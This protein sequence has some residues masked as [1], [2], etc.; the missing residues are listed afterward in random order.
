[1]RRRP[2]TLLV[3]TAVLLTA[4]ARYTEQTSPCFGRD[5][6]PQVSRA[7]LSLTTSD[8]QPSAAAKDCVFEELPRAV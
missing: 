7:A 1:M 3:T 4:C 6:E 2:L 5:G 8:A